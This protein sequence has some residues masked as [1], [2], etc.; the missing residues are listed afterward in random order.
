MKISPENDPIGQALIDYLNT[1]EE[2]RINVET[3]LTEDEHIPTSYFFRGYEDMPKSEQV[4]LDLSKGKIL[5]LG[6]GSGVHSLDLQKKGMNVY[7]ID[8]SELSVEV[9]KRRGLANVRL[10]DYRDIENEKYDTILL[11]MNGIGMAQKIENIPALLQQI[12]GLLNKGGQ[13]LIDS[14]DIL[15]MFEEEDGS[16]VID[17]NGDYY[18]EMIYFVSYKEIKGEAF[19]WF[20]IDFGLLSD[21][22]KAEGFSCEMLVSEDEGHYLARLS[23]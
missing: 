9:M 12:K 21:Y 2:G 4:A 5:D 15:Y 3:N 17:L 8:I 1:N 18:G 19:D 20:Y 7:P 23:L 6:A 10:Q 22:A 13:V 14:T 11:L 16:Y